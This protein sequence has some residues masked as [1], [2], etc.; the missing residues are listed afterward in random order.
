MELT[1][2]ELQSLVQYFDLL[3]EIEQSLNA[4]NSV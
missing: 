4:D 2:E 3:I 1:D